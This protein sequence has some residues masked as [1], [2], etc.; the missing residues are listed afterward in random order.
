MMDFVKNGFNSLKVIFIINVLFFLLV[1]FFQ[2]LTGETQVFDIEFMSLT[3]VFNTYLFQ[4]GEVWTVIT[5]GFLHYDPL[6]F[7]MNMYALYV[8][9]TKIEYFYGRKKLFIAY[10]A[11]VIFGS[12]FVYFQSIISDN[13]ISVLGASSGLFAFIGLLVGGSL[14][15]NRFGGNLPIEINQL[16]PILFWALIVNIIPNVSIAGHL[17]GFVAGFILGKLFSIEMGYISSDT[18]K[19]NTDFLFKLA[20]AILVAALAAYCIHFVN[21]LIF[22]NTSF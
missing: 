19:R 16:Y 13:Y 18:E 22:S 20:V 3:G 4:T 17:G 14:R 12:G 2:F 8:L 9:G 5:S 1:L 21:L 11:G 7:A 10:I 15:K 6:H